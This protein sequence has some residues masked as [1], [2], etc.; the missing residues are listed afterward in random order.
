ML[1]LFNVARNYIPYRGLYRSVCRRIY[2]N[3]VISEPGYD[4]QRQ[5]ML[6]ASRDKEVN[7]PARDCDDA[8][9]FC[10]ENTV[11][12]RIMDSG[13]SFHDTYCKE[14]LERF[15]LRSSK[16]RLAEDQTLDIVRSWGCCPSKLFCTSLDL[17]KM[18]LGKLENI[19][20]HNVSEDKETAKV[21]A[22]GVAI[23][24]PLQFGVAERLSRTFRAEST[25]IR[26]EASKMLWADSVTSWAG[27]KPRVQIEENFVRTD[28]STETMVDDML[29]VGSDMAEFNKPKWQLPLVFEMKDICSEKQVLGY[30]LTVGVTIV[31]WESRL[32]KSITI[33]VHQVGDEIKVE[34]LRSFNW[35]S[36]ELI[37]EDGFLPERDSWND[38]PCS[39]VHQVGDEIEVEVLRSFN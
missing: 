13:A 29:V 8:L 1:I 24:T 26:V 7:Q 11:E 20:L 19:I 17:L 31:E 12:D 33:D 14:E 9:V 3:K 37:M 35:P 4:K 16:V 10:V 36:S 18:C 5:K 28:S 30:V 22:I 39:D 15:K 2:P 38:E 27:R 25:R 34:F 6:I 21:G 23:E 32:Q